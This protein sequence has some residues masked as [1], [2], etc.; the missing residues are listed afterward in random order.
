MFAYASTISGR[1]VGSLNLVERL[2]EVLGGASWHRSSSRR[3]PTRRGHRRVRRA[4]AAP[5]ARGADTRPTRPVPLAPASCSAARRR[6]STT[7][8][9]PA[10]IVRTRYVAACSNRAPRSS[11]ISAARRWARVRSSALISSSTAVRTTG[12]VNS[13]GFSCRSRSARTSAL[14]AVSAALGS[15]PASAAARD[16][17]VRSPRIAAARSKSVASGGQAG[18]ASRD[19]ARDRLR[20]E[21][22]HM[23]RLLGGRRASPPARARRAAQ[24]GRADSHPSPSAAR[25]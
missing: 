25:R 19:A 11:R 22:E 10:G 9:S 15:S 2:T 3:C 13:S 23:R 24:R 12:C 1:R 21:L 8:G 17:S 4:R 16:S 5:R 14:A 18:E 7:N 6:V 20:P